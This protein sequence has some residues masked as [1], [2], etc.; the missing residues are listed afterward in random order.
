VE[1][2]FGGEVSYA[3]ALPSVEHRLL[4]L[5]VNQDV[6]PSSSN[7]MSACTLPCFPP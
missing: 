4:L 3:Q 2:R 7:T 5:P 6:D 1:G